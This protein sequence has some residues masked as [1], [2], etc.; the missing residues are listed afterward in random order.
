[1]HCNFWLAFPYYSPPIYLFLLHINPIIGASC[2]ITIGHKSNPLSPWH[3]YLSGIILV[4][5]WNFYI[6][7]L[8]LEVPHK[9]Y[10]SKIGFYLGGINDCRFVLIC[11]NKSKGSLVLFILGIPL[12][13]SIL[14]IIL[15]EGRLT[16]YIYFES[17]SLVLLYGASVLSTSR[18]DR[19]I[20]SLLSVFWSGAVGFYREVAFLTSSALYWRPFVR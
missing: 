18:E 8:W 15:R 20:L 2:L 10:A 6:S 4:E 19:C 12:F 17:N 5:S 9:N 14:V 7:K 11:V 3:G 13:I 1:M 16:L